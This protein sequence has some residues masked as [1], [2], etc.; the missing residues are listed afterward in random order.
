MKKETGSLLRLSVAIGMIV[1]GIGLGVE[2][3]IMEGRLVSASGP[4]AE[5]VSVAVFG[6]P[7]ALTLVGKGV[8]NL[9]GLL[10]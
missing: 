1:I 2:M 3:F 5:E 9:V 7:A 10:R 6:I 8:W 4:L